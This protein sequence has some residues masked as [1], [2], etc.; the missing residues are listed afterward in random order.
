MMQMLHDAG[1]SVAGR[2]VLEIGTGWLP[3]FP[4]CFLLA[5]AR[6]VHTFDLRR[7]MRDDARATV[8][9]HIEPLLGE[10]AQGSGEPEPVVRGRW[11]ALRQQASTG[12]ATDLGI[13]YHAPA[14]ASATGLP[15][16]SV[17]LIVS[18][19]VLE[20]VS[21]TVLHPLMRES[22]RL[23]GESGHVLHSVNCG[24]HYAYFDRRISPIH[25]LRFSNADWRRWNNDILY[26]NRLRPSDFIQ[27]A[28]SS[29]LEILH[30]IQ[31]VRHALM[32][33][34]PPPVIAEAFRHYSEEDL[35]TTSVTFLARLPKTLPSDR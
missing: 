32:Q 29:G 6:E 23:I 22:A 5:G 24:D 16:G 26:Q 12:A 8:L 31:T 1:I 7:H 19:S 2:S 9:T 35:C 25:Y 20:H 17:D 27:A 13:R 15:D 10:I 4:V 30:D 3:V 21:P 33:Q 28:R 18:N 14:D 34:S 11:Q